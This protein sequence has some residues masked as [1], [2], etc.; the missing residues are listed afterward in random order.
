M[1]SSDV[2]RNVRTLFLSD[3][4]LGFRL[5]GAAQCEEVLSYFDA[6]TIYLVGDTIDVLRMSRV[7]YWNKE[8]QAILDRVVELHGSKNNV[9]LMP[10]N[11][12]PCFGRDE[13]CLQRFGRK[14]SQRIEQ[15]IEPLRQ[16]PMQESFVHRT[17]DAKRILV[18]PR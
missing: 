5:S 16:L 13:S 18:M 1:F 8:H 7:W 14:T 4:H 9:L 2:P 10:G 6:D 15:V 3:L 11:H 12:D 17:V